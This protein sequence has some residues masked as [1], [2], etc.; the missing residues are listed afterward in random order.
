MINGFDSW[1]KGR[2]VAYR[3]E[4]SPV[5]TSQQQSS[6]LRLWVRQLQTGWFSH[7]KQNSS[8]C[9]CPRLSWELDPETLHTCLACPFRAFNKCFFRAFVF[10]VRYWG[11][12]IFLGYLGLKRPHIFG[13][14]KRKAKPIRKRLGKG[15]FN[16]FAKFQGLTLK[17]GVDILILRLDFCAVKRKNHRL[18]SLLLGFSMYSIFW[19]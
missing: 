1:T 13:E 15:A 19:L 12:R 2:M 18:A 16:T 14:K 17:N 3:Y 10:F 5:G 11:F 7:K 4:L 9:Q 8:R 6:A